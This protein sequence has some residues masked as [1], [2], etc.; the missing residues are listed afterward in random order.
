MPASVPA[1][2]HSDQTVIQREP[3]ERRYT[4][5]PDALITDHRVSHLAVRVWIRLATAADSGADPTAAA[6]A[7]ELGVSKGGVARAI[8]NLSRT[9]WITRQRTAGG[10]WTSRLHEAST[11][12]VEA[13]S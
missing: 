6:T 2:L 13:Q 4:V 10:V 5:V 8:L 3:R 9:G 1:T 12:P 7:T 11:V